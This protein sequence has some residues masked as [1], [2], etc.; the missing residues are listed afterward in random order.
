M[1]AGQGSPTKPSVGCES[2]AIEGFQF[3]RHFHVAQ[4]P[5]LEVEAALDVNSESSLFH[6]ISMLCIRYIG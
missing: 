1:G 5:H 6:S 4:L 3:G 2:I